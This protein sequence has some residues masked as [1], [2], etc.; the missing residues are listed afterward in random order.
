MST[1]DKQALA[2]Q[3]YDRALQY[4]LDYGCCPQCVLA[5]V[6]ETVGVID[7]SVIKASHGLSGGG[8]LSGKGACGALT[9]GLVALSAKRGRDRDKLDK[10]RFINN[11]RKGEE[12]VERFKAE[13]GGVTCEELQQQF[14]GRTYDMWQADQYQA[15]SDARGH[16]CA[17]ATATVTKWV[18]EMM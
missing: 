6:Q 5:A 16:K 14:T 15:F 4:E 13:F 1:D 11:F 7:D 18:V 3:A 8:G 2:Q 10:G 17:V 9:G 12:L